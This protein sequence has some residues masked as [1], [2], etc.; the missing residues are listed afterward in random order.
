MKIIE[1]F[2]SNNKVH[3]LDE[4][5]KADW[6]AAKFLHQF[7]SEGKL[8]E[9]VGGSA[10]VPL[11]TDGEKLVSFCTLAPLDDVQPTELSPWIG[12][13]YT[14]PEY[15]DHH[16]AGELLKWAEN[17]ATT[18]GH[19]A[20]YIST[21]HIELYEKYGYEFFKTAKSIDGEETRIYRK[22][23]SKDGEKKQ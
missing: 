6:G 3:W 17:T 15:R 1:Y 21:N 14:A 16:Y 10:L 9:T 18:M 2:A 8:K 12:F 13:V 5:A 19:E 7:L 20:V 22:K 4:I 11:L 23:L